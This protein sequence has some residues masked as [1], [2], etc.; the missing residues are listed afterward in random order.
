MAK[1]RAPGWQKKQKNQNRE[2]AEDG[3]VV[4]GFTMLHGEDAQ[5]GLNALLARME[6]NPENFGGWGYFDAEG[7][8]R[9][10]LDFLKEGG[11]GGRP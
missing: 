7:N 9:E 2:Q 6:K 8:E 5:E 1:K 4:P 11:K 3:S 10:N